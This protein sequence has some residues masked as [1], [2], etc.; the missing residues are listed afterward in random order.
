MAE[1]DPF[2]DAMPPLDLSEDEFL[3]EGNTMEAGQVKALR[4]KSRKLSLRQ[5]SEAGD[6]EAAFSSVEPPSSMTPGTAVATKVK[7]V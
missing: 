7:S 1:D 4:K 6:V 5:Q 3:A 2:G